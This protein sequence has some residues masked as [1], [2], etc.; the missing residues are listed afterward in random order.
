MSVR[1]RSPEASADAVGRVANPTNADSKINIE[2]AMALRDFPALDTASALDIDTSSP[3]LLKYQSVEKCLE[4]LL[5]RCRWVNGDSL[6]SVPPLHTPMQAASLRQHPQQD[7]EALVAV[8]EF[9]TAF[10]LFLI[11]LTAFLSLAQLPLSSND[12]HTDL[13]DRAATEALE[14]L[15]AN[16]GWL[17][18]E[19]DG[20]RDTANA[21]SE[22]HL[23]NTVELSKGNLQPGLI[24]DGVLDTQRLAA[25]K[26]ITEGA[27]VQGLGLNDGLN[28]RLLIRVTDSSDVEREGLILFEGGTTRDSASISSTASRSFTSSGETVQ[29]SVE[30]HDGGKAPPK[31]EMIEVFPAPN[32]GSPEWIEL[33]NP[34]GFAVTL[35][36]WSFVR[37][38]TTG[39]LNYLFTEGVVPG[40]SLSILTGS[41]PA[42][43]VGNASTVFDMGSSG[44]LGV[45]S[46][47]GLSDSNGRVEMRYAYDTESEGALV[48]KCVWT[49][50][51]G[52]VGGSSLD[53]N[54]STRAWDLSYSPTP[55]E[56]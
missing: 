55:G 54:Y 53:W 45:G 7:E 14:R 19:L 48:D 37:L 16:E 1:A 20:N 3:A 42:Q 38:G 25:L 27:M 35:R 49:P 8:I 41:I 26:N 47:D 15:T 34:E 31:L 46:I 10:A 9:L 11:I 5:A 22:W 28:M 2:I 33:K 32:G 44:F 29:V 56:I 6:M 43:D 50:G 12:P 18:P 52:V 13:V 36:G 4:A 51:V 17:V 40:N 21:T 23:H 24:S 39:T 30:V